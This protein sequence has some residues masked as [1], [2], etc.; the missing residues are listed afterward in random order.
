[1]QGVQ[2]M[3]FISYVKK[4]FFSGLIV[5]SIIVATMGFVATVVDFYPTLT[6]KVFLGSLF[7]LLIAVLVKLAIIDIRDN[8][9]WL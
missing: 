8:A 5:L 2:T 4:Q 6:L 7:T 1:M 3:Q 9:P